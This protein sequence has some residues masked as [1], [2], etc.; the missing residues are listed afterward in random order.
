MLVRGVALVLTAAIATVMLCMIVLGQ[1]G[2]VYNLRRLPALDHIAE[3]VGRCSEMAKELFFEF[4]VAVDVESELSQYLMAG[5]SVLDYTAQLAAAQRVKIISPSVRPDVGL[6]AEEVLSQA[7]AR[8]G[9]PELYERGESVPYYG[10][11]NYSFMSRMISEL[12]RRK[13][14]ALMEFG[15]FV[16]AFIAY[17]EVAHDVG[18]ITIAGCARPETAWNAITSDHWMMGEQV[19]AAAAYVSDNPIMKG[20]VVAADIVKYGV[21]ALLLVGVVLRQFGIDVARLLA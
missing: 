18:A 13:P 2:K 14:G 8:A 20:T 4:G 17:N 7:Y 1:R 6:L 9:N 12:S 16:G 15:G 19:M 5:V 10:S 21:I 11:T 3:A